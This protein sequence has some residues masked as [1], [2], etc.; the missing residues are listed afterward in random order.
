M[1][2]AGLACLALMVCVLGVPERASA[3]A[4]A[5]GAYAAP[6]PKPA[7][8]R[9]RTECSGPAVARAGSLIW[10]DGRRLDGSET[11]TFMGAKPS[12]DEVSVEAERVSDRRIT[13][14]IPREAISGPVVVTGA[15][16]QVSA[17][18]RR[19]IRVESVNTRKVGGIELAVTGRKVFFD[20][21]R[22]PTLTFAV[23]ET[24]RVVVE[25][26]R[27]EDAVV[28]VRWDQGVVPAGEQRTVS[29]DGLAGGVVQKEGRYEF[30]VVTLDDAG[31]VRA[32]SAQAGSPPPAQSAPD[33]AGPASP[34]SF[35]FLRNKF[36]VRGPHDYG[37]FGASFGGGRNHQGHDVFARCGTPMVAARGGIVKLK[38]THSRAGNYLVIDGEQTD[39]DYTYMHLRDPALVAKGD[40]VLTGQLIGYVGDTGRASGCHLH[41]ELWSGPGWYT[42]GKPFDPLPELKA[43]DRFS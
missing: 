5:G 20:G 17:P 22:R 21:E 15:D 29:W 24:G 34:D 35:V 40:R 11:V 37:K 2:I 25:L 12:G 6:A 19:G 26:V 33:A 9:C 8:I 23:R 42:G 41:F 1:L 36:P 31:A 3:Q 4:S 14:R 43:W 16:G 13:V 7:T 30:R 10:I 27:T 18:T 39:V 28:V 38:Q 32:S